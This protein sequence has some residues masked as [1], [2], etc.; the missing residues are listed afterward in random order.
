MLCVFPRLGG[1]FNSFY[2]SNILNTV[3]VKV[4]ELY[5]LVCTS[6]LEN[7]VDDVI[8]TMVINVIDEE[9]KRRLIE[10]MGGNLL[11]MVRTLLIL[12]IYN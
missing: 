9:K 11:L 8:G 10:K 2:I 4:I 6:P 5:I 12:Y 7:R 1:Q 3:L